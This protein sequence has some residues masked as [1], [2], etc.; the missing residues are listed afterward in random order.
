MPEERNGSLEWVWSHIPLAAKHKKS[1]FLLT[2]NKELMWIKTTSLPLLCLSPCPTL[3]LLPP[4]SPSPL[5]LVRGTVC[6]HTHTQLW[7][8]KGQ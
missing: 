2:L 3:G 6:T 4:A 1:P 8:L 5:P 7:S